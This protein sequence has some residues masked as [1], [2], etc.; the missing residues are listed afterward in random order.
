MKKWCII[1]ML[2]IA[3]SLPMVGCAIFNN[4]GGWQY[5]VPQLTA[6]IHMFSKL[7]TRIAL[8]EANMSVKD[9]ELV[10]EYLVAL[11]DLLV[12]PGQPNF[13]GARI[14]VKVRLP[15]K[16]QIYGLTIID[17]IERYIQSANLTVI[18]DQELITALISS[19]IN[20]ALAAVQEFD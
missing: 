11:R 4:G 2:L 19:A 5:N 6:D 20:G 10:E 3:T 14:L 13:T 7:A 9:A 8:T 16:Y 15:Q 17:M 18:D 12:V 1:S